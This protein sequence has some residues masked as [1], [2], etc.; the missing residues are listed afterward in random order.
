MN[1]HVYILIL[2][3]NGKSVLEACIDSVLKINYS[4]Y[5]V[6]VIDNNSS[7]GSGNIIKDKYPKIEYLQLGKNYGFAGGYNKSFEYLKDKKTEFILLLN[8]DTEVDSEI[9]K[10]FIKASD[11]YGKNNI[12]G[13]KIFYKKN[14]QKIWY[15]GGKVNLKIGYIAH[16]GIHRKDSSRYSLQQVTDYVT[17]CCFFTTM[18]TMDQLDGFD[19]NFNMYGEDVDICLRARKKEIRCI[20]LPNVIL[21]HHVSASIGGNYSFKKNIK[22]IKSYKNLIIKHIIK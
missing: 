4:N 22:K 11:Y 10:N 7:D 15:A 2:N 8:N 5:T 18:E 17:G 21:W 20:F 6:L 9:L 12:Y 16:I 14:P 1:P 19:T 3:W 13:G